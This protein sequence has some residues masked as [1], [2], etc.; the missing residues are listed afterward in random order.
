M[1]ILSVL[2]NAWPPPVEV[3][4]VSILYKCQLEL[5]R[6]GHEVHILTSVGVWD[7]LSEPIDVP[8]GAQTRKWMQHEEK[9]YGIHFHSYDLSILR[10]FPKLAFVVNRLI[11]IFI[12]PYLSRIHRFDIIHEYSSM[13]LLIYRSWFFK[14]ILNVRVFHSLISEVPNALWSPKLLKWF[15]P[16]IDKVI[17]VSN[18]IYRVMRQSGYPRDALTFLTIGVNTEKFRNLPKQDMIRKKLG[19]DTDATVFL[20]LAPLED[21]KG[22]DIYVKAANIVLDT[23]PRRK[24]IFIVATYDS[25]G[26]TPYRDRKKEIISL[27]KRYARAFPFI[28][29]VLDVPELM[30]STDSVVLPQT[31]LDG[32]TGYPVTMLEAMSAKKIVIASDLPGINE[33]IKSGANGFLFQIGDVHDLSSKM[34]YIIEH[35]RQLVKV[36]QTAYKDIQSSHSVRYVAEMLDKFYTK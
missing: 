19:I 25:P 32:A 2:N 26:R 4:G 10:Q 9:R 7:K 6:L 13:P 24:V 22:P 3:T 20:F 12:I 30:A 29:G 8:S 17:C 21:H 33:V 14:K 11:P 35:R 16:Q 1:K 15:L 18:R 27:T 34:V 36:A 5:A 23:F 31:R 28:E